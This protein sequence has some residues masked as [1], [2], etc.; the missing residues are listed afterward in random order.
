VYEMTVAVWAVV[1][2]L[3]KEQILIN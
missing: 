2:D 1:G 3:E